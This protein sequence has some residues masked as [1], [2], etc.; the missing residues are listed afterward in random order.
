MVQYG[1]NSVQ[2]TMFIMIV[3]NEKYYEA[4]IQFY[5]IVPLF[6]YLNIF[7]YY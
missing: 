4:Q 6:I 2:M 5:N 1:I 7:S 3:K